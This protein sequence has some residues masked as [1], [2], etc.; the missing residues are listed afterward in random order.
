MIEKS[1]EGSL[2]GVF[3]FVG[4]LCFAPAVFFFFFFESKEKLEWEHYFSV[5]FFVPDEKLAETHQNK[6][7]PVFTIF[8][9]VLLG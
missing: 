1:K 3:L 6:L 7:L 5:T 8:G 4:L 9:F 2:V